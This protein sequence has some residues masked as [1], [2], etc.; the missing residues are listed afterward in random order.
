MTTIYV[1]RKP[2]RTTAVF[3]AEIIEQ[4]RLNG[5]FE[6]RMKALGLTTRYSNPNGAPW[7]SN[8]K[9]RPRAYKAAR[10]LVESGVA[11]LVRGELRKNGFC[12]MIAGP[13]FPV[14]AG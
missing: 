7:W 3:E 2:Q 5:A 12:F 11:V 9:A 8:D 13:N 4:M 1:T 10:N 14:D 6:Q